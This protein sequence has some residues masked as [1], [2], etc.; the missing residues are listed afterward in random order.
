MAKYR[1]YRVDNSKKS[2]IRGY[3]ADKGHIY[4]DNIHITKYNRRVDLSRG[5]KGLFDRGELSAFYTEK[6]RA[7][8]QDR[9]GKKSI[10]YNRQLLQRQKLSITEVKKLIKQYGGIT[11]YNN[12]KSRGL[13]YLEIWKK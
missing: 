12:K 7:I 8:I 3:W 4:K 2:A 1:L 5:V 13:Y 6:S 9:Q 10:L 11:I